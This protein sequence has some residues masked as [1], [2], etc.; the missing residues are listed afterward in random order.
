MDNRQFDVAGMSKEQ[1]KKTLDILLTD[2][3]GRDTKVKGYRFDPDKGLI[4]M[5]HVTEKTTKFLTPPNL[6]SLT[7]IVWEWL[8]TEEAKKVK[9]VDWDKDLDHDGSNSIGFRV[10]NDEWG[11]VRDGK[12]GLD[13][14]SIAAIK[15]K[16]C[17]YGK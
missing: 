5:W 1:L 3:Y 2:E 13:H 9:L 7:D 17:W 4:L 12:Y 8:K 10:Y 14:Y 16:Y 11:H 15:P 6:N